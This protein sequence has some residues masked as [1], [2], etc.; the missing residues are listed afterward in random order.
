M[1]NKLLKIRNKTVYTNLLGFLIRGGNK[2][3]AKKII[4]KAFMETSCQ[5][6]L[7][8]HLILVKVFSIINSSVET[9]KIKI[10]RS[11]HIVPSGVTSKRCSYLAIKWLMGVVVQDNRKVS[12]FKKL[13]AELLAIFKDKSSK[14]TAKKNLNINQGISNRSNIHYRW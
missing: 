7:P 3:V 10:K 11:T 9:K 5:A 2:L 8:L 1:Y 6:I 14:T 4:D 12:T 13:S